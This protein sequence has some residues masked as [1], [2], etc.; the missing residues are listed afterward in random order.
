MKQK[1]R[2]VFDQ[3]LAEQARYQDSPWSRFFESFSL[4][5]ALKNLN[6]KQKKE[7]ISLLEKE[8]FDQVLIYLSENI[9]DFDQ[10]FKKALGQK[11][12]T[13]KQKANVGRNA[14]D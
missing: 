8:K 7:F 14:H 3:Y 6:A 1:K 5:F 9:P 12:K 11:L 13:I 4:N 10:K 2:S